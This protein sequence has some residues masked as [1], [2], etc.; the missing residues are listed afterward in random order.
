MD[1]N[2]SI[3]ERLNSALADRYRVEGEIGRG[4]MATVYLAIGG[5]VEVPG[6]DDRSGALRQDFHRSLGLGRLAASWGQ[7]E[8]GR[9][10][11]PGEEIEAEIRRLEKLK[12]DSERVVEEYHREQEEG[13]ES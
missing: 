12:E 7:V 11:D 3:E 5:G 1:P 13:E 4:G 9:R 8:T 10:N 2:E 6:Q